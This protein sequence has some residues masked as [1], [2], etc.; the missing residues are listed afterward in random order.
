VTAAASAALGG[1][2]PVTVIAQSVVG[3]YETATL[4]STDPLA[5]ENW[6]LGH[7]YEIPAAVKPI[8]DAYVTEGF[9]FIAMRLLPLC[10]V[11]A[12]QPVR[13]VAPGADPTLPLRMVRRGRRR[14]RR[15]HALRDRRG[16]IRSAELPETP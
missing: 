7:G 14:E 11:R 3:P 5:L 6:L 1:D 16:S 12:M 4:R 8:I 2:D 15:A 9:D 13:I 10:G